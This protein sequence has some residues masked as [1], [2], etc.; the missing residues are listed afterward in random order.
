MQGAM[1]GQC[2]VSYGDGLY[3]LCNLLDL[4]ETLPRGPQDV[5]PL[6]SHQN[7]TRNGE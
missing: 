2:L 5:H 3:H 1:T 4:A 6:T 7:W